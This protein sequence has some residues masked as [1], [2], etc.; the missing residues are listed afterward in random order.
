MFTPEASGS[1]EEVKPIKPAARKNKKITMKNEVVKEL[2]DS[3]EEEEKVKPAKG[4]ATKTKKEIEIGDEEKEDVKPTKK[5]IAK[6]AI[7]QQE[8]D[9]SGSEWQTVIP[10]K[11]I[12]MRKKK[13]EAER[14]EA[15]VRVL[16]EAEVSA[17][18][19]GRKIKKVNQKDEGEAKPVAATKNKTSTSYENM[20]LND[21]SRKNEQGQEWN[22]KIS[23]WN[24]DGIRAW[25]KK[26]GLDY[27]EHEKPDILCLQE[28]KCSL[29]KLPSE[30]TDVD[31]YKVFW[32][33][34]EKDGYAG[35]ALYT[36]NEP[37]SVQYGL[38]VEEHDNEGRIITAEYETFYVLSVYVPNSGRGLVTLPRRIKWNDAFRKFVAD[39]DK[40]KPVII[41]GDMNVSHLEIGMLIILIE[42]I[43]YS[44]TKI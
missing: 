18:P 5:P 4:T 28:T 35:V 44:F 8:S 32:A 9:E 31:G 1:D 38:G 12:G 33:C 23:N 19:T 22:F 39:L 10:P 27:I 36:K 20:N 14:K 2:D 41:C 29:E 25:I 16:L 26:G 3:E 37:L 30:A 15:E 6:K 13:K 7:L 42:V 17:K 21:C 40:K 43:V 34:S 24:V 11:S